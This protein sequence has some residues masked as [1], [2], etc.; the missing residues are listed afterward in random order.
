MVIKQSR[1]SRRCGFCG[2]GPKDVGTLIEGNASGNPVYTC[3]VCHHTMSIIFEHQ[4]K[5]KEK[6]GECPKKFGPGK[7]VPTAV[8]LKAILDRSI[9]GQEDAK[10]ALALAF[11]THLRQSHRTQVGKKTFRQ[12]VLIS[13]PTGSGK[14]EMIR[15]LAETVDV[16]LVIGDAT[17][18]T[19][20]GYVGDDVES[21][22]GRLIQA[23]GGETSKA[24]KGVIFIDEVD[25]IAR[26][27]QSTS[28]TRDVS[29]EGVQ[30]A[31]L[32]LV[33]GT[34]VTVPMRGGRKHPEASMHQI[35]TSGI[36]FVA[37]GSFDGINEIA[38]R[39]SGGSTM[40]FGR[41]TGKLDGESEL[42]VEDFCRFGM[43]PEFMGRFPVIRRTHPLSENDLARILLEPANSL[44]A[45]YQELLA[46]DDVRLEISPKGAQAIAAEAHRLGT[47][48]RGLDQVLEKILFPI[49]FDPR[50][51]AGR[52]VVVGE[53]MVAKLIRKS[54]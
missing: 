27:G 1:V 33:E 26:K 3:K 8:E 17:S 52:N 32:K 2:K 48:A 9:I 15:V 23:S 37:G 45:R 14:T 20:A 36:L 21:L 51:Y 16:P 24:E 22:V 41:T 10:A 53:D 5:D 18:L 13:G 31:L 7:S 49:R 44:A 40:G 4:K 47:G 11:A 25:K 28:I 6:T 19:E 42:L 29:G 12:N 39:R 35:E 54:V 50:P 34:A 43:I 30:Q 46:L 38:R